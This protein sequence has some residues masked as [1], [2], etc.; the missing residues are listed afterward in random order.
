M[1]D[2]DSDIDIAMHVC[3]QQLYWEKRNENDNDNIT[4][5]RSEYV[6]YV[7]EQI[8]NIPV[9]TKFLECFRQAAVG[10]QRPVRQV[11]TP[12]D[13]PRGPPETNDD[14]KIN[15][16]REEISQRFKKHL[17]KAKNQDVSST[18]ESEAPKRKIQPKP[19]P[20]K[21][22]STAGTVESAEASDSKSAASAA[23]TSARS[24]WGH[25]RAV[26]RS[27]ARRETSTQAKEL[28][29]DAEAAQKFY[30][31]FKKET[32]AIEWYQR[33]TGPQCCSNFN[34]CGCAEAMFWCHPCG[35][36]F[37]LECRTIGLACDHNIINY[38]SEL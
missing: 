27:A 37:C 25:R 17:E 24:P 22:K 8:D 34:D 30:S 6:D 38:S 35:L 10:P 26:I 16:L 36:A 18:S 11:A 3:H 12:N 19:M 15:A 29:K 9:A 33:P 5:T 20:K 32:D 23:S 14:K 1:N 4:W 21:Q 31:K 7:A 2:Y 28:F 13:L